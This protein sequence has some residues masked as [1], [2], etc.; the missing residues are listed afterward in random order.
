MTPPHF[1]E[2]GRI[3][4]LLLK[5]PR[6]AFRSEQA[7]AREWEDLRFTAPPS[8]DGAI[9]E[10]DAFAALVASA[11]AEISWLPERGGAGLDSIYVRDASVV[12]PDGVILCHSAPGNRRLRV[13]RSPRQTCPWPGPFERPGVSKAATSSG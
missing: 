10:Y 9:A 2:T 11:G 4:R 8:F 13:R 5:H 1:D 6:D 12:S 3:T 7:I